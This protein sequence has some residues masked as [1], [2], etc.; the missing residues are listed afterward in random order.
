MTLSSLTLLHH[1]AD[2]TIP[3][4]EEQ[5]NQSSSWLTRAVKWLRAD[6][7]QEPLFALVKNIL[8]IVLAV[9]LTASLLGIPVVWACY[10]RWQ[11]LGELTNNAANTP[12]NFENPDRQPNP[13]NPS[14]VPASKLSNWK[15]L[16]GPQVMTSHNKSLKDKSFDIPLLKFAPIDLTNGEKPS[17]SDVWPTLE[18]IALLAEDLC[19]KKNVNDLYVCKSLAAFGHKLEEIDR[20][21]EDV[22]IV[23]IIPCYQDWLTCDVMDETLCNKNNHKTHDFHAQHRVPVMIDKKKNGEMKICV[24]CSS[25]ENFVEVSKTFLNKK[26]GFGCSEQIHAHIRAVNLQSKTTY[27]YTQF[28]RHHSHTGGCDTFALQ[29]A[30]S[31]LRIPNFF[32]EIEKKGDCKTDPNTYQSK[33]T[34]EKGTIDN[35]YYITRL[36]PDFV[37]LTQSTS[38]I[39]RYK[40][41]NVSRGALAYDLNQ[42]LGK[43]G[44]TLQEK[45]DRTI[46]K[47]NNKSINL[48]VD[49][50][51]DSFRKQILNSL[52]NKTPDEL[53][54][55]INRRLLVD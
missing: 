18:G 52:E 26:T 13:N 50:K 27:Y 3:K 4:P 1:S 54:K 22:H 48:S 40:A 33:H 34:S 9:L 5:I 24:M 19:T 55:K 6:G 30:I 39:E 44:K 36:P 2:N 17:K 47:K 7:E 21:I 25:L 38:Q 12:P 53:H 42:K 49:H 31:F 32:E 16:T 23:L 8:A 10:E 45:L 41:D 46:I 43:K 51:I 37:R 15:P 11:E 28:K 29:D 35:P 14:T 20:S